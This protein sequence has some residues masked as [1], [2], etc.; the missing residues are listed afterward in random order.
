[1]ESCLLSLELLGQGVGAQTS[2]RSERRA[3]SA[4]DSKTSVSALDLILQ[5]TAVVQ[6][7]CVSEASCVM[8]LTMERKVL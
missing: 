3:L 4:V 5:N 6:N 2:Q 7:F 1:M 8:K